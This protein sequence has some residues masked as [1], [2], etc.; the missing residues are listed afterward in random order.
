MLPFVA[1]SR[2]IAYLQQLLYVLSLTCWYWCLTHLRVMMDSPL[3]ICCR[4][5]LCLIC[6]T[7]FFFVNVQPVFESCFQRKVLKLQACK[8]LTDSSLEA[9]YK[10]GTLQLYV[11]WTYHM[12]PSVSRLSRSLLLVVYIPDM[13]RLRRN[14]HLF[15]KSDGKARQLSRSPHW[16]ISQSVNDLICLYEQHDDTQAPGRKIDSQ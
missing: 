9:L 13:H 15:S 14:H 2:M 4:I 3:C 7:L 11:S 1:N 5:W 10:E 6:H 8:Y 12:G 16:N